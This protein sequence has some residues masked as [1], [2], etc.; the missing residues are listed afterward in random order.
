MNSSSCKL[1]VYFI[2]TQQE[3][4]IYLRLNEL[5][6][7]FANKTII[8]CVKTMQIYKFLRFSVLSK[9]ITQ[10]FNNKVVKLNSPL[11]G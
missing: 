6:A 5:L 4:T 3:R 11:Y 7:I 8:R 10:G 2:K 1:S 9:K